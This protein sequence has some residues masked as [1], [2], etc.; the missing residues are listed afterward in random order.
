MNFFNDH[1]AAMPAGQPSLSQPSYFTNMPAS[2]EGPLLTDPNSFDDAFMTAHADAHDPHWTGSCDADTRWEDDHMAAAFR[3][4]LK[5]PPFMASRD[6]YSNLVNEFDDMESFPAPTDMAPMCTQPLTPAHTPLSA[7]TPVR[8]LV[9]NA[10]VSLESEFSV[11]TSNESYAQAL[12]RC[13]RAMPDNEAKLDEIYGWIETNTDK[14]PDPSIHGW[15]NS[16]RHNLSMNAVSC[17]YPY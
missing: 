1:A 17:A 9:G 2:T 4:L 12:W 11:D 13:L 14:A 6:S 8:D 15:K 10:D 7:Q 16:V 3:S 5:A